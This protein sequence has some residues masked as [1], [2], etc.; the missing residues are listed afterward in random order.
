MTHTHSTGTIWKAKAIKNVERSDQFE[1]RKKNLRILTKND[2]YRFD[3]A[4]DRLCCYFLIFWIFGLWRRFIGKWEY[5]D[6]PISLLT[7]AHTSQKKI[8]ST[9]AQVDSIYYDRRISAVV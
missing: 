4:N 3:C 8:T 9:Q 7:T 6:A 5:R 2:V 1:K